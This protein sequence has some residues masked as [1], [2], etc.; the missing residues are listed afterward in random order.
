MNSRV[1]D[2]DFVFSNADRHTLIAYIGT[3]GDVTIPSS[4]TTIADRAFYNCG[5]MTSVTIPGTVTGIGNEAFA[6]CSGL[7]TIT[8]PSTVTHFGEGVL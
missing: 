5:G 1:T 4:V 2:G 6:G 7:T 3:G 8:F